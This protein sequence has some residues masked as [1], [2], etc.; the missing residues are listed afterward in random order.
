[1]GNVFEIYSGVV[2]ILVTFDGSDSETP[3]LAAERKKMYYKVV[4]H[5]DIA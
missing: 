5:R 1:M 3:V 4:Y 2:V